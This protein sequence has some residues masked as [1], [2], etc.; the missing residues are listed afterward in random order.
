MTSGLGVVLLGQ[1]LR[2]DDAGGVA[3]PLDLDVR[4]I[5]VENARAYLLRSLGLD[6][7]VTRS[8]W[9]RAIRQDYREQAGGG[10]RRL[11]PPANQCCESH[12]AV[13]PVCGLSSGF[14]RAPAR[15]AI[16][17][18]PRA[19]SDVRPPT[20]KPICQRNETDRSREAAASA[21]PR[22]APRWPRIRSGDG[23]SGL[24]A[25]APAPSGGHPPPRWGKLGT[26][27]PAGLTGAGPGG[28]GG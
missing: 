5:L 12:L 23:A 14:C 2:G 20:L 1:Q 4:V 7:G 3:D 9:R 21:W 25:S 24:P 10:Q 18:V 28:G 22:Y 26:S 13:S 11:A 16:R 19:R 27:A 8:G 17:S 6:R 15:P